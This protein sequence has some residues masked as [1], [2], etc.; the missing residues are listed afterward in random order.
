MDDAHKE[1]TDAQRLNA[2]TV[3]YECTHQME[4]VQ[5]RTNAQSITA[6]DLARKKWRELHTSIKDLRIF[7][8]PKNVKK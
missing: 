2:Y 8:H 6:S 4:Y 7:Y 1:S 5:K 3:K